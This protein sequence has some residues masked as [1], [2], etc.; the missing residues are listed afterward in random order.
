M[1]EKASFSPFGISQSFF[2]FF[3]IQYLILIIMKNSMDVKKTKADKVKK[4]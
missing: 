4:T 3:I 2:C 1:K